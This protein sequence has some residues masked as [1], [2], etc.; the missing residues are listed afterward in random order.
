MKTDTIIAIGSPTWNDQ[1]QAEN[2]KVIRTLA[3]LVGH[4]FTVDRLRI[5]PGW[6]ETLEGRELEMVRAWATNLSTKFGPADHQQAR[7]ILE[8]NGLLA[9]ASA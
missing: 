7:Q 8:A 9:G 1:I 6:I 3:P 4:R 2:D 5:E